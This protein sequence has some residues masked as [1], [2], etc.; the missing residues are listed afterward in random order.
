MSNSTQISTKANDNNFSK[1]MLNFTHWNIS[2]HDHTYLFRNQCH[3]ELWRE[4]LEFA[5][6]R[7]HWEW[8]VHLIKEAKSHL[9][10]SLKKKK[11]KKKKLTW[12]KAGQDKTRKNSTNEVNMASL[13]CEKHK[14]WTY[15]NKVFKP[16][17]KG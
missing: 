1:K 5:K 4:I 12:T 10:R 13:R 2:F 3:F 11:R 14:R 17:K 9:N 6:H 15:A 16:L 8:L 7:A